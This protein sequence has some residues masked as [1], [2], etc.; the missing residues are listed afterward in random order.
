[1]GVQAAFKAGDMPN[2]SAP[3]GGNGAMG[4]FTSTSQ[5]VPTTKSEKTGVN[6]SEKN[7]ETR[8]DTTKTAKKQESEKKQVPENVQEHRPIN[9]LQDLVQSIKKR[10]DLTKYFTERDVAADGDC[11][12]QSVCGSLGLNIGLSDELRSIACDLI[13]QSED[14]RKEAIE[15][16]SRMSLEEYVE[17]MRNNRVWGSG[18]EMSDIAREFSIRF[19]LF[20]YDT[21]TNKVAWTSISVEGVPKN[22]AFLILYTS[23]SKYKT[24]I[25][26]GNHY[27]YLLPKE[28]VKNLV[29]SEYGKGDVKT[30]RE[31]LDKKGAELYEA[32]GVNTSILEKFEVDKPEE[33]PEQTK[34]PERKGKNKVSDF[35]KKKEKKEESAK[36]EDGENEIDKADYRRKFNHLKD[37]ISLTKTTGYHNAK[38]FAICEKDNRQ[39][40]DEDIVDIR[41]ALENT[42]SFTEVANMMTKEKVK[43][44]GLINV[45]YSLP[46]NIVFETDIPTADIHGKYGISD[47]LMRRIPYAVCFKCSGKSKLDGVPSYRL[48]NDFHD[49]KEHCS[50]ATSKTNDAKIRETGAKGHSDNGINSIPKGSVINLD[51][52]KFRAIEIQSSRYQVMHVNDIP[53]EY[54]GKKAGAK[55]DDDQMIRAYGWNSRTAAS[56]SN[57]ECIKNFLDKKDP[58]FLL[59]NEC[60]KY[61][62]GYNVVSTHKTI[63]DGK[64]KVALMYSVRFSVHPILQELHNEYNLICKCNSDKG[65]VII[66]VVYLPPDEE[67]NSNLHELKH[68]LRT[69]RQ[70]YSDMALILFGDLNMQRHEA[71]KEFK[72][73]T[74]IGFKLWY[75]ESELAYTRSEKE[76]RSYLDYFITYGVEGADMEI[77]K[78]IGF[79]DHWTVVLKIDNRLAKLQ[80]K[81]EL[82]Q[83]FSKPKKDYKEILE[84]VLKTTSAESLMRTVNDL[85]VK[86]K[87]RVRKVKSVYTLRKTVKEALLRKDKW[88]MFNKICRKANNDD[89][90]AF[91]G[92]L[93]D[94]DMENRYKEYFHRIRFYTEISRN[95]DILKDLDVGEELVI[96]RY[97]INRLVTGRYKELLADKGLKAL[98]PHGDIIEI[99]EDDVKEAI[100]SLPSDKAVSWDL[101]PSR[102]LE[103]MKEWRRTDIPRF[104]AA[105][106]TF[107]QVL[108]NVLEMPYLPA[109]LFTARLVCLNKEADKRGTLD[110]IRPIAVLGLI[111]KMIEFAVLKRIIRRVYDEN[112][113]VRPEIMSRDQIGF[114]KRG[115]TDLNILKL[116]VRCRS[117]K[118]DLYGTKAVLFIDLKKAYDSVDHELLFIKLNNKGFDE[119]LVN[120][121]KKLYSHA[122]IQIGALSDKM[123]VNRGVL[124]GSLI[125]PLLFNIYIDDLVVALRENSYDVLAYADDI[126]IICNKSQL[127]KCFAVLE[128]WS[129]K[130]KIEINKKKSGI[131]AFDNLPKL[132][133]G[134]VYNDFPLVRNYK[135]LGVWVNDSITF[136]YQ[137]TKSKDRLRDYCKRNKKL[138]R[139][140]F[141]P[142]SLIKIFNYYQKSRMVYGMSSDMIQTEG[143]CRLRSN[144]IAMVKE[145]L[146]MTKRCNN[147][148]MVLALAIPDL[149]SKLIIQ[150]LKNLNK[151]KRFFGLETDIYDKVILSVVGKDWYD[152]WKKDGRVDIN[153]LIEWQDVQDM[154]RYS[155]KIGVEVSDTFHKVIREEW[156]KYYDR[157]DFYVL[158][159]FCNIGFFREDKCEYCESTGGR[160]HF[161]NVCDE[162]EE[163]RSVTIGSIRKSCWRKDFEG[164]RLSD[165]I[166]AMYYKPS[167]DRTKRTKEMKIIKEFA[168]RVLWRTHSNRL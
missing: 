47:E 120:T 157:R 1:M 7:C 12:F 48:Y 51:M 3:S 92:S 80:L 69:I 77:Q 13:S 18:I 79:S 46:K 43:A 41:D 99:E 116:V 88:E 52:E 83:D 14:G 91:M 58:D 30:I 19:I 87:P 64:G 143:V 137:I 117:A 166:E 8:D 115:G 128:D 155:A 140:Y 138:I 49:L 84:A 81:R 22:I 139:T 107:T 142:R 36:K 114:I 156:Y 153:S 167:S 59:L 95:Q 159:Y 78:P 57:K 129:V 126:A 68:R 56:D 119:R 152:R 62:N 26:E 96:D 66:Y 50:R 71:K 6:S 104:T 23:T 168:A 10:S 17:K 110:T 163:K 165:M 4:Y 89:Y 132:C 28:E 5:N 135:Y 86:Y 82:V 149:A 16:A 27:Q 161:V 33:L 44:N 60:R 67:H 39:V 32:E 101:I 37:A 61:G 72:D 141:S 93:K 75:E 9:N 98:Y 164:L 54:G 127:D 38:N 160:E 53:A 123:N 40:G 145:I 11:L 146:G 21:H 148:R 109:E 55:P 24:S 45:Y 29:E 111:N 97:E 74:D 73:T 25:D 70:R 122:W 20:T 35:F 90:R 133:E 124:Q 76:C 63:G 158:K 118:K 65:S 103:E 125:S 121:I 154:K 147:M 31:R 130:N 151:L 134:K 108:N 162:F 42:V 34:K 105:V 113:M 2:P 131:L 112:G 150:L 106:S 136:S 15:A 94:L 102:I 85:R 144:I 100:I